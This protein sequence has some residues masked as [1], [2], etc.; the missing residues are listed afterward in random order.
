MCL[1]YKAFMCWYW[2][3]SQ[4]FYPA[5]HA[6]RLGIW[7]KSEERESIF[8]RLQGVN[9]SQQKYTQCQKWQ[10][11]SLTETSHHQTIRP[12]IIDLH[13]MLSIEDSSQ[14]RGP[15]CRFA[16]SPWIFSR[17]ETNQ[18]MGKKKKKKT[19]CA[20]LIPRYLFR[21]YSDS[22]QGINACPRFLSQATVKG[23]QHS[24][25]Y[26]IPKEEA[27]F[28]IENHLLWGRE[29]TEFISWTSSLLW[30]LQYAV[31]KRAKWKD[32]NITIC[33]LDIVQAPVQQ[34]QRIY[35]VPN[36]LCVYDI[37]SRGRD[38]YY[39]AEYLAHSIVEVSDKSLSVISFK[40][41]ISAGLFELLPEL[42]DKCGR[43]LLAKRVPQLRSLYFTYPCKISPKELL[44]VKRLAAG[45]GTD[46]ILPISLAFLSLRQ[47]E[48]KDEVLLRVIAPLDY[49]GEF[50]YRFF[51]LQAVPSVL[52]MWLIEWSECWLTRNFFFLSFFFTKPDTQP[53]LEYLF[54]HPNLIHPIV[55]EVAEFARLIDEV[56]QH[57]FPSLTRRPLNNIPVNALQRLSC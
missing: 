38:Y 32:Q 43:V 19:D 54:P 35:P 31:R 29:S 33:V 12:A 22:S 56:Y 14:L 10:S 44:L 1:A 17:D 41:L 52:V 36:L 13:S 23:V 20:G 27:R 2:M 42:D 8:K 53:R 3:R 16:P 40:A 51:F 18:G 25:L 5:S 57:I 39:H 46:W 15:L 24:S 6:K 34:Q 4:F 50:E 9:E 7:R 48:K 47:R 28:M 21:T 45:F 49:S 26:D 37:P 30:A 55:P 11:K